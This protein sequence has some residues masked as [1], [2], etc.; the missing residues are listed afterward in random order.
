VTTPTNKKIRELKR[1][2]KEKTSIISKIDN[3]RILVS[4]YL[5]HW[6][7][8]EYRELADL[9]DKLKEVSK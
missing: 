2:I 6:E 3:H 4:K 8:Q 9:E 5:D 7:E 1:K